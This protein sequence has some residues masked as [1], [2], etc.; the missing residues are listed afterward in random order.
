M[1][2]LIADLQPADYETRVA[3]LMKKAENAN[4][5]VNDDMYEVICLIAESIK[6]NIREL[7]GAFDRIVGFSSLM[8]EKVDKVFARRILKDILQ[9]NS[10]SPTPEKI[11]TIVSRYF[12]IDVTAMESS[13]RTN[14]VAYPRQIAMYLCRELTDYSLPKIGNLFGGRHYT[15]VMHACDKIQAGLKNDEQLKEIVDTLKKEISE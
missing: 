10:N 2:N 9:N 7:E 14:S 8:D 5:D 4:I 12:H 6:N 1:W 11:K 13:K 3:I 15:T